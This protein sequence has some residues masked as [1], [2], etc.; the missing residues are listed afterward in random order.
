MLPVIIQ[1]LIWEQFSLIFTQDLYNYPEI[2]EYEN[3]KVLGK[4]IDKQAP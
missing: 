4:N 3:G 2:L 1:C